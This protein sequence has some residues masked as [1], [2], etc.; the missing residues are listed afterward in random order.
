MIL[1]VGWLANWSVDQSGGRQ[2]HRVPTRRR[3]DI[4]PPQRTRTRKK[5]MPTPTH[6][7]RR[8]SS[9]PCSSRW[10][11]LPSFGGARF[12]SRSVRMSGGRWF[13]GAAIR[14]LPSGYHHV[15]WEIDEEIVWGVNAKSASEP[16]AGLR[17]GGH[18][19]VVRGR[20]EVATD[21]AAVLDLAGEQVLL[22]LAGPVP[23]EVAGTWIELFIQSEHLAVYPYRL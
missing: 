1:C 11:S 15:E 3:C 13:V 22:D 21:G 8:A 10:G 19:V 2:R 23:A 14:A 7:A 18:C 6:N 16:A 20:L 17:Q 5:R 4:Y 12:S 9:T